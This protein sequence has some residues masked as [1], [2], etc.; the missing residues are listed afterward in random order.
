MS[1]AWLASQ[2]GDS[3][4]MSL[5]KWRDGL[6]LCGIARAINALEW[7]SGKY[8]TKLATG[9]INSRTGA[10]CEVNN[11]VLEPA[12]CTVNS[13]VLGQLY[14]TWELLLPS[15]DYQG[16]SGLVLLAYEAPGRTHCSPPP[17]CL[18]AMQPAMEETA[19][20]QHQA[21]QREAALLC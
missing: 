11:A 1:G 14:K 13:Q 18:A 9:A 3:V 4:P 21:A 2:R 7:F 16:L 15:S 12:R 5:L 6:R 8:C 17:R 10:L 19:Y 20:C